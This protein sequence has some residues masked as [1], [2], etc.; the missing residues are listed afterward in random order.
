MIDLD[1]Y[2]ARIGY[3]GPHTATLETL[4]ALHAL[5]SSTTDISAI[6]AWQKLPTLTGIG[7]VILVS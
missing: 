3:T 7:A 2:F 4:H 1:A 6:E 5:L